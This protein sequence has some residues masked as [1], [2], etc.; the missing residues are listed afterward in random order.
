MSLDVSGKLGEAQGVSWTVFV[1][2]IGALVALALESIAR[3]ELLHAGMATFVSVARDVFMAAFGLA[4]GY[5]F[6]SYWR[7]LRFVRSFGTD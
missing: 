1:L 5:T 2:V 6:V 3:V 4:M 7:L